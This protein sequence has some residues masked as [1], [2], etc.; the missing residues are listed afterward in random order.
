MGCNCVDQR[1]LNKPI[2]KISIRI[3]GGLT[4]KYS[5]GSH[6]YPV[7]GASPIEIINNIKAI[8]KKLGI[9]KSDMLIQ[10]YVL[11]YWQGRDPE[12][13]EKAIA[14]HLKKGVNTRSARIKRA[15]L[16]NPMPVDRTGPIIW[17]WL[18]LFGVCFDYD[19]WMSTHAM[20]EEILNP[21]SRKSDTSGCAK[22]YVHW[23][24]IIAKHPPN[25][26]DDKYKAAKWVNRMHNI[27]NE[28]KGKPTFDYE[29]MVLHFGAP[30]KT[31]DK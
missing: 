4:V 23:K 30:L 5:V 2:D 28:S 29:Q 16:R 20:V 27:V 14:T 19:A 25:M 21:H 3:E 11:S 12:G 6:S 24:N 31:K 1:H 15:G 18:N 26:V 22:C 17:Q 10:E 9:H 8:N 7:T 13:F